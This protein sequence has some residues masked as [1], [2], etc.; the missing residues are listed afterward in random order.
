MVHSPVR[1]FRRG[2]IYRFKKLWIKSSWTRGLLIGL[3]LCEMGGGSVAAPCSSGSSRCRSKLLLNE[4]ALGRYL[5]ASDRELLTWLLLRG[6]IFNQWIPNRY[7]LS[8]KEKGSIAQ[9]LL[10]VW[11]RPRHYLKAHVSASIRD[12]WITGFNQDFY[13]FYLQ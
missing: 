4:G 10:L 8:T 13:C 1:F 7:R 3:D 11:S 9:N 6:V 2:L 12:L 5:V